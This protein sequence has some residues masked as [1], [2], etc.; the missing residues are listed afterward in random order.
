MIIQKPNY[1]LTSRKQLRHLL[2]QTEEQVV[3]L[4]NKV[5]ILEGHHNRGGFFAGYV[6]LM[7]PLPTEEVTLMTFRD[8]ENVKGLVKFIPE[9][10]EKKDE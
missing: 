1:I 3:D 10:N 5:E 4:Q 9:D 2:I 6:Q 8:N 7:I